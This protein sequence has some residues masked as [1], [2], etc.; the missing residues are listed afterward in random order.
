VEILLSKYLRAAISY[1]GIHR[2]ERLPV[3]EEALREALLNAIIHRDYSVGA[4][5]QIR[6]H[7]DRLSIW[8][9]GELPEG[10]SLEKLLEPHASRP[11]NPSVANAFF[12]AGEIEAW[13]R[14]IQR[15]LAAC[16]EDGAPEPQIVYQPGDLWFEFPFSAA[17]LDIIPVGTGSHGLGGRVGDSDGE[18]DGDT[19]G[20]RDGDTDGERDGDRVGEDLTANQQRILDLLADNP[21]MAASELAQIVGITKRNIEHNVAVLKKMGRLKRIGPAYGGHWEVL[22]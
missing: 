19:D 15:I 6:V 3:P 1:Q 10:W 16:Q 4:P 5:I 7:D 17:Y 13:G 18:R 14:G 9:P 11:H 2:V 8:N 21:R 20:E 12:R 22:E